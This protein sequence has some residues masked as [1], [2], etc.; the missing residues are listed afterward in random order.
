MWVFCGAG[1]C[2]AAVFSCWGLY[3]QLDSEEA[4]RKYCIM[5]PALGWEEN[6]E[7]QV[8]LGYTNSRLAWATR[9]DPLQKKAGILARRI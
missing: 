9:E 8:S 7:F 4:I 5:I 1:T 3:R 6:H 2:E